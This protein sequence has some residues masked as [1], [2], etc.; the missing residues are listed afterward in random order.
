MGG[1]EEINPQ[2]TQMK[3]LSPPSHEDTKKMISA[4][5]GDPALQLQYMQEAL[6]LARKG[7]G[8]TSPNP[9]VGAVIVKKGEM[10]GGGWHK[11]A[12]GAHAEIL[13]LG[14]AGAR[15]RG[16]DLYVTLE[17]CC[18]FGRTAPCT[19]AI[20]AAGIRRVFAA[21]QD[22]NPKVN[23]RGFAALRKAGIEVTVGLLEAEARA[24]N[25]VY[26]KYIT[27]GRPF[28]TLKLAC[29]LDGKIA[30]GKG[31]SR[32]ITGE[33]ARK[34]VHR[35]RAQNDAVLVGAATVLADD[36]EFTVRLARGRQPRRV[37][38]DSRGQ[39]P[40]TA[41]ILSVSSPSPLLITTSLARK[42][43]VERLARAGAEVVVL[44]RREARV[45]LEDLM[46]ALGDREIT[47]LLVEG[48]G[49][50]AA[51][52]LEAGLVDKV[53]FI[54]APMIIGGEDAPSAVRGRGIEKLSEAWKLEKPQI[55]RLGGDFAISG[56][57]KKA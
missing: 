32:W 53:W 22:P 47:S 36:P 8:K 50:L 15:A 51:G 34:F 20:I 29:S 13:A 43:D 44:P 27:T 21:W 16:A 24:L 45:S 19:E 40:S 11:R 25:E 30:T 18:H 6:V 52:L 41:R 38:L 10:V 3:K 28:V 26:E 37:I 54:I 4:G 31:E 57:I 7:L 33:A 39:I 42:A 49:K 48:G 46:E 9:M 35:L 1:E 17:P 55:K 23:G 56:N 2:I 12:G 5:H 14:Q